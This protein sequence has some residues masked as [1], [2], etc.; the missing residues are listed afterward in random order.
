MRS[1]LDFHIP[2]LQD[3][4]CVLICHSIKSTLNVRKTYREWKAREKARGMREKDDT[5]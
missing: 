3:S 5:W 2:E 4:Q 1:I